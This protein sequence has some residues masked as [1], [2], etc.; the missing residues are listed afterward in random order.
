MDINVRQWTAVRRD[1]MEAALA[2]IPLGRGESL[3]AATGERSDP[4]ALTALLL[5]ARRDLSRQYPNIALEFPSGE[6][7]GAIY[8]AGFKSLRTLIWMQATL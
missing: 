5:Q 4:E 2:W 3:F 6:F 7:D 1:Q 8:A